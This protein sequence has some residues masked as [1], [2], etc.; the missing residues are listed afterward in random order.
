MT[1]SR[2]TD[3]ER[4]FETRVEV[5]FP[6]VD[7]YLVVWHGHYVG[8]FEIGRNAL[9]EAFGAGTRSLQDAGYLLPVIGLRIQYKHPAEL[10]DAITIRTRLREPRAA[11]FVCDY[12]AVRE[13]DGKLLAEAESKQVVLNRDRELLVTLP[14]LLR[15]VAVR[16]REFHRGA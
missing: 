12:Q 6:E 8:W 1:G 16:I 4:Y 9:A 3:G 15:E 11:M 5:R 14:R 7:S 2:T 13:R 10:G